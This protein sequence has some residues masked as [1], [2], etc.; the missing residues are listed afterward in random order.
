MGMQ[1]C[2]ASTAHLQGVQWVFCTCT[3]SAMG[4]PCLWH[5][6]PTLLMLWGHS[7]LVQVVPQTRDRVQVLCLPIARQSIWWEAEESYS[8]VGSPRN[9]FCRHKQLM[10]DEA[11]LLHLVVQPRCC[12]V[13]WFVV[14]MCS[15]CWLGA[16]LH[17]LFHVCSWV[18]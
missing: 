2:T 16:C 9:S 8:V 12:C 13:S 7:C 10:N 14:A 1:G 4:N 3:V 6:L 17:I 5:R 11:L 15:G 18:R